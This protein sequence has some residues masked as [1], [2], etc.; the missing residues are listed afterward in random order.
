MARETIMTTTTGIQDAGTLA[1]QRFMLDD[2]DDGGIFT[3]DELVLANAESD[4][5]IAEQLARLKTVGDSMTYGGG[6]AARFTI[7]RIA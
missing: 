1:A 2:G 6:A 4:S 7:T 3:F 5:T